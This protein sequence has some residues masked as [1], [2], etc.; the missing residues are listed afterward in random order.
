MKTIT[1]ILLTVILAGCAPG[2]VS[3]GGMA[4]GGTSLDKDAPSDTSNSGTIPPTS[5][6]DQ[7]EPPPITLGSYPWV[8]ITKVE[9]VPGTANIRVYGIVLD[10]KKPPGIYIR[11]GYM[12]VEA[13]GRSRL[14]VPLTVISKKDGLISWEMGNLE[15]KHAREL[16]AVMTGPGY[17]NVKFPVCD[18][19]DFAFDDDGIAAD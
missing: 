19:E 6:D 11:D 10:E 7:A 5:T 13:A 16:D 15:M 9:K 8:V 17:T 2:Q 18:Y 1:V 14:T 12:F 3:M 4:D